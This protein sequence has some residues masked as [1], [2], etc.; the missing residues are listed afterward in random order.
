[1]KGRYPYDDPGDEGEKEGKG[2]FLRFDVGAVGGA[3][4][5]HPEDLFRRDGKSTL[6]YDSGVGG[7]VQRLS[8]IHI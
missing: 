7:T 1:M 2:V 4:G 6:R 8:L 5:D 3:P